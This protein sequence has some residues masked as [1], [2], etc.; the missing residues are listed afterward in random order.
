MKYSAPN[1]LSSNEHSFGAIAPVDYRYMRFG[2]S[3]ASF[4]QQTIAKTSKGHNEP[5]L[6][7]AAPF[8]ILIADLTGSSHSAHYQPWNL[9]DSE[10]ANVTVLN[11][12]VL[13]LA[14][15]V[16]QATRSKYAGRVRFLDI[17]ELYGRNSYDE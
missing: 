16:S 1:S 2:T 14:N 15:P 6:V 9:G 12:S 4:D 17:N 13:T 5:A 11:L 8:P 3:S 10:S 7:R